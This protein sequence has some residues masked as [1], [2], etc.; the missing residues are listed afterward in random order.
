MSI[1]VDARH[2]ELRKTRGYRIMEG[3]Q[4]CTVDAVVNVQ[5]P[6]VISTSLF[7]RDLPWVEADREKLDYIECTY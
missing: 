3:T 6:T 7:S 2:I 1:Y 5:I 4:R